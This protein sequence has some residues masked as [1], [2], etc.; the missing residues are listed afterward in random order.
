L[1][2]DAYLKPHSTKTASQ[3]VPARIAEALLVSASV[4]GSMCGRSEASWWRDHAAGRIPT[5]VKLGGRTLWRAEELR[6]WV[7]AGC[8]ARRIWEALSDARLASKGG[9]P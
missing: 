7:A 2:A 6:A 4:A 3:E 8:P 1:S 5:P 9:R